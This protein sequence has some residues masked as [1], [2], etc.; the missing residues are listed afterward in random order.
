MSLGSERE[1]KQSVIEPGIILLREFSIVVYCLFAC[2][3]FVYY[4]AVHKW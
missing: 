1:I 3:S 2:Q 4:K